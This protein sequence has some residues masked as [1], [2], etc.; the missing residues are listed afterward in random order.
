MIRFSF[1]FF[2]LWIGAGLGEAIGA[3]L[4][5]PE[6][7]VYLGVILENGGSGDALAAFN[8]DAGRQRALYG[9]FVVFKRDPF[10]SDWIAA[11]ASNAP[12]A[13]LHIILEPFT[14]FTDF[15]QNWNPGAAPYEAAVSFVTNCAVVPRAIFLRF[16]HE[17][18]G[19]RGI[20]RVFDKSLT[21]SHTGLI[22]FSRSFD[23]PFFSG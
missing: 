21:R 9:K 23:K 10:P 19:W 12:G 6:S 4:H 7:G 16:A 22:G 14:D 13:A 20:N 11:V 3:G 8:R 2:L 5:E 1:I 18:N 15:F 17:Q